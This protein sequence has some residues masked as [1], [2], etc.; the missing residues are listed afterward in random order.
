ML[1]SSYWSNSSHKPPA[2]NY[3]TFVISPTRNERSVSTKWKPVLNNLNFSIDHLKTPSL[4]VL[5]KTLVIP[6]LKLPSQHA[7]TSAQVR[8]WHNSLHKCKFADV[9]QMFL[10]IPIRMNKSYLKIIHYQ[11]NERWFLIDKSCEI[12]KKSKKMKAIAFVE[13]L[14]NIR[15]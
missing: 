8:P 15:W 7:F 3:L 4:Y 9:H 14:V 13:N 12:D 6:D 1:S 11:C 2:N 5:Y 10:K